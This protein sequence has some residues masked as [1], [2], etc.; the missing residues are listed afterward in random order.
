[1]LDELEEWA[2][3]ANKQRKKDGYPVC[4]ITYSQFK[5]KLRSMRVEEKK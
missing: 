1:V 5:A 4:A 3:E 2:E